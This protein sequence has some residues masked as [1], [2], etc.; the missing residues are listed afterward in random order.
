MVEMDLPE[1]KSVKG[2]H[3]WNIL[4]DLNSGQKEKQDYESPALV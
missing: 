2:M 4:P 3:E 1:L